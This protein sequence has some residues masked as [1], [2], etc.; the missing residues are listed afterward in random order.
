MNEILCRRLGSTEHLSIAEYPKV[1]VGKVS[2][3]YFQ[4]GLRLIRKAQQEV[5]INYLENS[6]SSKEL[7]EILDVNTAT[8]NNLVRRGRLQFL[9]IYGLKR[10]RHEDVKR[11]LLE[12]INLNKQKRPG[13][14]RRFSASIALQKLENTG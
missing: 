12:E 5:E 2:E 7:A 3:D 9:T 14:P 4:E 1:V 13:R 6:Y 10:F 11:F 8:V